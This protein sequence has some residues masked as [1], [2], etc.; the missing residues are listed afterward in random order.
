M[1]EIFLKDARAP[2]FKP[3][4]ALLMVGTNGSGVLTLVFLTE[5]L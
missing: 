2:E 1:E 3:A 5:L 4:W